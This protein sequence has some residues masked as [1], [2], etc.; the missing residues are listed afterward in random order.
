MKNRETWDD[1]YGLLNHP[2]L[3]YG[4]VTSPGG[5]FNAGVDDGAAVILVD[6]GGAAFTVN[7][8]PANLNPGKAF[9]VKKINAGAG[10]VKLQPQAGDTIE[11]L[12]SLSTITAQFDCL[13]I[14]SDGGTG[15]WVIGEAGP[16]F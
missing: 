1:R 11:T 3:H 7:L 9:F 4:V 8:P 13:Q 5:S 12:A 6:T 16:S 2:Y 15:W 10:A 14:V